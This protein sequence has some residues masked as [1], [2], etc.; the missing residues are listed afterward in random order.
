MQHSATPDLEDTPRMLAEYSELRAQLSPE[1]TI[2]LDGVV[3][4]ITLPRA[5]S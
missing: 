3:A 4:R 5:M 1:L 2:R